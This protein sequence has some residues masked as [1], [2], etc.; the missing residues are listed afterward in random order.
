MKKPSDYIIELCKTNSRLEKES[1][2]ADAMSNNEF[3]RGFKRALDTFET[4]GVKK[5]EEVYHDNDTLDIESY[6]H[7]LDN[8]AARRLT[9]NEARDKIKAMS[10]SIDDVEWNMFYRRVLLKNMDCGVNVTTWNK[11][12]KKV[13]KSLVVPV[14]SCQLAYDG[15]KVDNMSGEKLVEIKLDGVRVIAIVYSDGRVSLHS[16]N[17]KRLENFPKIEEALSKY[18]VES[19]P[20]VFDGEVMSSSFQDLMK[21]VHRKDDVQTDDA[22]LYLFDCVS[23][24]EF[25]A[26]YSSTPQRVRSELL[27]NTVQPEY[28]I[29]VVNQTPIDLDTDLGQKHF[30]E[31]NRMAIKNG[32]EGVM[33]KDPEAPY[34]TKRTKSWLKIKPFI[35][36]TLTVT[37]VQEGTGKYENNTGALVC[38]GR[39][40]GKDILVNVGSGLSDAMRSDIWADKDSVVGQLVEIKAD[41]VTQNQDGTYSLR[42]PRFKSFRGFEPGEKL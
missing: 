25:T 10:T 35:E 42:F 32:Y 34:E 27:R 11:V 37:D 3:V 20:L 28:C 31:I 1:I 40:A 24:D 23:L 19:C 29:R 9:G 33:I 2:L 5:V 22:V 38:A 8:L 15:A 12:A 14:F 4:F 18:A 36:V 30:A 7:M 41:A 6:Y 16:R 17:G 21:Q 26:G 39:D 13:D